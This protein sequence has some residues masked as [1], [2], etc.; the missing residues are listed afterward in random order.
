MAVV[1]RLFG[2]VGRNFVAFAIKWRDDRRREVK[3]RV[4]VWN[5][6]RDIKQWPL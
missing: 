6:R 3:T 5:V 4:N 2:Q 1:E